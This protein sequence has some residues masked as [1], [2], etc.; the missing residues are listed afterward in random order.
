MIQSVNLSRVACAIKPVYWCR[1]FSDEIIASASRT[2]AALL[3]GCL[4][5]FTVRIDT[6]AS[7]GRI[8][9]ARNQA[10][11]ESDQAVANE[12]ESTRPVEIWFAYGPPVQE[13]G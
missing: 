7:F 1:L 6:T 2:N 12:T 13:E 8:E 5:F 4:A 10:P 11:A 9:I 3:F